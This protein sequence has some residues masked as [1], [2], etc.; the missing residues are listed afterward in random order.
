[1]INVKRT[2]VRSSVP[3]VAL[4][5]RTA[6][7]IRSIVQANLKYNFEVQVAAAKLLFTKKKRRGFGRI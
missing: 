5:H 3:V 7:Y 6:A 4:D 1:M 2:K